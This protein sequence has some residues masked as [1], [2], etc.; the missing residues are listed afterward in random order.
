M[1][2]LQKGPKSAFTPATNPLKEYIST[3]TVAALQ[4]DEFNGDDCSGLYH[5]VNR[6]LNTYTK[7]SIH[8]NIT[9]SEH[10]ALENFRKDK[11]HIIITADKDVTLVALNKTEYV[12][13]V[14]HSYKTTQF[15]NISPNTHLKLSTMNSLHFCKTT[16]ITISSLKQNT[17]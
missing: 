5:D 17:P 8:T 13:H 15:T 1:S 4:S 6:I 11:A 3:T 16:R 7:K 14:Q 12:K 9:K 2:L 10:L